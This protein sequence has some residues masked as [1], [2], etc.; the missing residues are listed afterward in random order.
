MIFKHLTESYGL[1]VIVDIIQSQKNK[2]S[3]HLSDDFLKKRI[4]DIYKNAEEAEKQLYL[5]GIDKF[6]EEIKECK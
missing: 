4:M 6:I 1:N 3:K 5:Q 2:D